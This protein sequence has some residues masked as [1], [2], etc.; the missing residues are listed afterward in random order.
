MSSRRVV[1]HV[2]REP[3]YYSTNRR[4]ETEVNLEFVRPSDPKTVIA[5]YMHERCWRTVNMVVHNKGS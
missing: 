3:L 4:F 2:C 1:C 5:I